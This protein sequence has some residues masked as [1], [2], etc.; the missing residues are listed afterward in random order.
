[1]RLETSDDYSFFFQSGVLSILHLVV[2]KTYG[3]RGG[4]TG[5]VYEVKGGILTV[6]DWADVE[7]S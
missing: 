3:L 1:M 7:G 4:F 6:F 5:G 2:A